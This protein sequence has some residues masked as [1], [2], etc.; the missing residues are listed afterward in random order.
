MNCSPS[1]LKTILANIIVLMSCNLR[2]FED[3]YK[4][5]PPIQQI[6]NEKEK[7]ELAFNASLLMKWDL[8]HLFFVV[9]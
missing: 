9:S 3:I 5:L 1:F 4:V 2:Q 8:R 6:L 7:N